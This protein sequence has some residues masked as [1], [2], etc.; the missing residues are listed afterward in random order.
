MGNKH[1]KQYRERPDEKEVEKKIDTE[2][3]IAEL[4]HQFEELEEFKFN[5][6]RIERRELSKELYLYT[7]DFL[8]NNADTLLPEQKR[9]VLDK[10]I[11]LWCKLDCYLDIA[12]TEYANEYSKSVFGKYGCAYNFNWPMTAGFNLENANLANISL[13]NFIF[14]SVNFQGADFSKAVLAYTHFEN[15]NL[16]DVQTTKDTNIN[17]CRFIRCDLH[18]TNLKQTR[19]CETHFRK[20]NLE[21]ANLKKAGLHRTMFFDCNTIYTHFSKNANP[22]ITHSKVYE[23]AIQPSQIDDKEQKTSR[24]RKR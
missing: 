10:Y 4:D 15:C 21:E 13:T 14:L 2:Q 24:H 1:P 11:K 9:I 17:Q 7:K 6:G 20:C 22:C 5:A 18:N 23:T 12:N 3:L 8:Q 16:S 19:L